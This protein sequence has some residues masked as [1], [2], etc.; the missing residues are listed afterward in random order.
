M[1]EKDVPQD[2]CLFGPHRAVCYA[3][4]EGGEY[5][6]APTAGW[7]PA[8]A[9]NLQAWEVVREAAEEARARVARGEASPLAFHMACHQL[10]P[11]L[12][13]GAAGV[14]RR[15][16]RRHLEPGGLAGLGAEDRARYA[17]ALGLAPEELDRVPEGYGPSPLGQVL[18]RP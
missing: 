11:G 18:G 5:V 14:S 1:R 17:R 15:A 4:A 2:P 9:A 7:E 16:V 3:V 10:D 12:L 8:N 13:A 6:R